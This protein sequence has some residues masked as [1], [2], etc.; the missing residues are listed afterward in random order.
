[1][2]LS[3]SEKMQIC[4]AGTILVA[5]LSGIFYLI[6]SLPPIVRIIP[7]KQALENVEADRR[8]QALEAQAAQQQNAAPAAPAPAATGTKTAP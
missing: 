2:A 7:V 1:M 3:K 4:V 6:Y 5:L 8:A